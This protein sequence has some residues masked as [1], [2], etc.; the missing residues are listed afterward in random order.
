MRDN[1]W[2]EFEQDVRD[3]GVCHPVLVQRE[4]DQFVLLDGRH[5]V[6]AVTNAGLD[7]I[8]ARVLNLSPERQENLI[9]RE[10]L[11]RR[12][13]T[14]DQRAALATRWL[15]VKANQSTEEKARKGGQ[16]GG[17]GR[18]KAAD[19]PG[20][21]LPPGLSGRQQPAPR[22]REETANIFNV[23]ERRR[24]TARKLDREY[25]D[26]VKDALEG[27]KT[28]REANREARLRC[29]RP[30]AEVAVPTIDAP[31]PPT[32]RVSEPG[33]HGPITIT[34]ADGAGLAGQ[35]VAEVGREDAVKLCRAVLKKLEP[36][37][38]A[39]GPADAAPVVT[40]APDEPR[41]ECNPLG[42]IL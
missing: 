19:S 39:E 9:L 38:K 36:D 2:A 34:F 1:Q 15:K 8:R 22:A 21:I 30:P 37:A 18:A 20:G 7:T 17:R 23:P 25:P 3:V 12:Q 5:R 33:K 35:L 40:S 28:L 26:L 13:L 4:G 32:S 16:A 29:P 24:R 6:R 14:D 11:H 10:A 42:E 27:E 41:W 31:S